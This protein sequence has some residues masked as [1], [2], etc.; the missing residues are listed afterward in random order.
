MRDAIQK[1]ISKK[2]KTCLYLFR[3]VRVPPAELLHKVEDAGV[4]GERLNELEIRGRMARGLMGKELSK[5]AAVTLIK[6]KKVN[7]SHICSHKLLICFCQ[8][9][10]DHFCLFFVKWT[11]D[12]V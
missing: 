7:Q 12:I 6:K 2:K 4:R 5:E 1:C 8:N 10:E 3:L 11:I 9:K